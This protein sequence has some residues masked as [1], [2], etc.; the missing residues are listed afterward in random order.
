M[1]LCLAEDPAL[2]EVLIFAS[3][4][5]KSRQQENELAIPFPWLDCRLSR[6]KSLGWS[7]D[8]EYDESHWRDRWIID[9]HDLSLSDPLPPPIDE[10]NHFVPYLYK[11]VLLVSDVPCGHF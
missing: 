6:F 7:F 5:L 3:Y 8:E 10:Q 11:D 2:S 4:S 9:Y 1:S